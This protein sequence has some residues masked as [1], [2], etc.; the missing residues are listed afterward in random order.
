MDLF[1]FVEDYLFASPII[2]SWQD[3]RAVFKKAASGKP[4][5]WN[6]PAVACEAVGGADNLAVPAMTSIACLHISIILIDDM[7]DNDPRGEYIKLGFPTTANL[8]VAFNAASY[9]AK[10]RRHTSWLVWRN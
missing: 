1:S 4:R 6:L 2:A 7:L 10:K 5:Q 3:M 8:A 9:E